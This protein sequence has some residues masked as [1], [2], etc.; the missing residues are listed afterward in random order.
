MIGR[1][2][3]EPCRALGIRA[4]IF[5]ASKGV[6]ELEVLFVGKLGTFGFM[7]ALPVMLYGHGT[8]S[9]AHVFSVLGWTLVIPSLCCSFYAAW[10]YLPRIRLA[11]ASTG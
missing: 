6:R 7:C 9:A 5:V 11:L 10:C 8:G 3:I 4:A 2:S 1:I